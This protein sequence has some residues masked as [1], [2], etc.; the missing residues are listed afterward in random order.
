[1]TLAETLQ[2]HASLCDEIHALLLEEN[3]ILQTTKAAPCEAFL[4]RKR[5]LL[6]RLDAAK[7]ALLSGTTRSRDGARANAEIIERL[8]KKTLTILLLDRENEKL[9][10]KF[11]VQPAK[12]S[13]PS[14]PTSQMVRRAYSAAAA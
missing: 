3:R 11:I 4:E 5:D 8:Q 7:I 12:F 10:L 6:P 1:M 2:Q 14:R 13:V 9:L